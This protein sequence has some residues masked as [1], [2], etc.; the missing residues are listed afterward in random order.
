MV[1]SVVP[2]ARP[3]FFACVAANEQFEDLPLARRKCRDTGANAVEYALLTTR[4]LVK[5][6]CFLDGAQQFVGSN[7]LG[8]EVMR[9]SLQGLYGD[10]CVG[11]ACQADDR[12][13]GAEFAQPPLQGWA[14]QAR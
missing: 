6:E 7:R 1:R 13:C 9:T 14:V 8:Q 10:P 5:R 3:I 12:H 2:S 11:I 4:C